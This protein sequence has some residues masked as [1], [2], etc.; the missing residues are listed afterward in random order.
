MG[1]RDLVLFE[2]LE[3][4]EMREA[5]SETSTEGEAHAWPNGRGR[6]TF[7]QHVALGRVVA[8]HERRVTGSSRP[9]NGPHGLKKQY[10]CTPMKT[11]RNSMPTGQP[12]L[13]Y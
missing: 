5:T 1:D 6:W 13:F 10:E 11:G 9:T 2:H 4:A 3:D 8:R 12:V 7:V